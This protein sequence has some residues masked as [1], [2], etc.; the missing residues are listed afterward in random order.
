M[1]KGKRDPEKM[2][3]MLAV[4]RQKNLLLLS[5]VPNLISGLPVVYSRLSGGVL[6]TLGPLIQTAITVLT[7]LDL[8]LNT[9][10]FQAA[11]G[12]THIG[13]T[14]FYTYVLRTSTDPTVLANLE[15]AKT[16]L[17]ALC[18]NPDFYNYA[19]EAD[20]RWNIALT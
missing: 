8:A 2:T 20:F 4:P 14:A 16:T 3:S 17:I 7:A 15:T 13:F 5:A 12:Y 19:T 6:A 18:L 11:T 9:P 1:E 10:A